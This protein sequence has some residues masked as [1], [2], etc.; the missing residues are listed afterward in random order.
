MVLRQNI[1]AELP[2]NADDEEK[3]DRGLTP[4]NSN[5]IAPTR[6]LVEDATP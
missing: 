6:R 4:S 3:N 5:L 1:D 2:R